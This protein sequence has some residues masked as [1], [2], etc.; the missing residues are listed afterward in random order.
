MENSMNGRFATRDVGHAEFTQDTENSNEIT[1]SVQL[2]DVEYRPMQKRASLFGYISSNVN[3][4]ALE[5]PSATLTIAAGTD[6]IC[7]PLS[8]A[9]SLG[10]TA[11]QIVSEADGDVDISI[12]QTSGADTVYVVLVMPNGDLVVSPAVTFA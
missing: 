5:A 9:N 6:G 10:S 2:L 7:I 8:A 11:F 1:V 12:T 3:G 4:D